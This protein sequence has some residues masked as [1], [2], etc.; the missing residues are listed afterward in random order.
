MTPV[1]AA[2]LLVFLA[3]LLATVRPLGGYMHLVFAG[4]STLLSPLLRPIEAIIYRLAGVRPAE[5][6]TWYRYALSFMAIHLPGMLL[7]YALLRLQDV[8]PFNPAGQSAVAP[9]LALN[10]AVSF[11]TNTSWPRRGGRTRE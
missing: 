4:K 2:Q 9:D 11:A 3:I 8:L 10:T 1:G 6:Q 7:L 5:E